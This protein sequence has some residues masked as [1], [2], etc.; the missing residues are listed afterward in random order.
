MRIHACSLSRCTLTTAMTPKT[1]GRYKNMASVYFDVPEQMRH[2]TIKELAWCRLTYGLLEAETL[3]VSRLLLISRGSRSH[4]A[5]LRPPLDPTWPSQIR[6]AK[7]MAASSHSEPSLPPSPTSSSS[8]PLMDRWFQQH[9]PYFQ[10]RSEIFERDQWRAGYR[11]AWH[12]GDPDFDGISV[13]ATP[14]RSYTSRTRTAR[15]ISETITDVT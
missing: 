5:R 2:L 7:D 13:G 3:W 4:D 8:T 1:L 14:P 11:E 9:A 15:T 12:N 10:H 6:A